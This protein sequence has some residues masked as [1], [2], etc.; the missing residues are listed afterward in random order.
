MEKNEIN[1]MMLEAIRCFLDGKKA[2]R[3]SICPVMT[4]KNFSVSGNTIKSF[5]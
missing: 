4:G 3:I 5:R 2:I 1:A